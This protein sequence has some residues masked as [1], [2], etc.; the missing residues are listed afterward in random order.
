M[1][2]AEVQPKNQ[3]CASFIEQHVAQATWKSFVVECVEDYNLLYRELREKRKIPV[4][5]IVVPNGKLEPIRRMYSDQKMSVLKREHGFIEYLD[6]ACTAID[7]IMQALISKHNID[8]V[9]IGGEAVRDSW[10]RK[11]LQNYIC[12]KENGSGLMAACFFFPTAYRPR[13][14]TITVSNYSGRL[15]VDTVDVAPAKLLQTGIDPREKERLTQIIND[16]NEKIE[17]LT[18][19]LGPLREEQEKLHTQGTSISLRVKDAKNIKSDYRNYKQKLKNQRDKVAD[20]EE[21]ANMDNDSEKAKRIA[22]IKKAIVASI[23]AGEDAGKAWS[24]FMKSMRVVTGVKMTEH[25]LS[26]SLR[27]LT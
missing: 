9:L 20:A 19:N 23:K 16:A 7:P 3:L 11:D 13:K 12:S 18:P 15:G 24:E 4:N 5:I 25:S 8:K 1:T 2:A 26:E 27:K 21:N 17:R 6:E 22:T 14:Y 10:N